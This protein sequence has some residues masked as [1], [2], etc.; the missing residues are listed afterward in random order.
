MSD[1]D[2]PNQIDKLD[3]VVDHSSGPILVISDLHGNLDLL[4]KALSKG[5]EL[6]GREDIDVVLL[7]DYVDNGP[8]VPALLEYLSTEQWRVTHPKLRVHGILGNHDLALLLAL[9]PRDFNARPNWTRKGKNRWTRWTRGFQNGGGQTHLQYDATTQE[10]FTAKFPAHH[11]AWLRG[12]PWYLSMDG[13]LFVHAGI[14]NP[15]LQSVEDQLRYLD[16]KD[17]SDVDHRVDHPHEYG[18]GNYGMPDQLT[19]KNWARRNYPQTGYI[20]VTGHNKFGSG[21]PTKEKADFVASHR[22]GLHACS[23]AIWSNKNLSL[24]CALLPRRAMTSGGCCET[25]GREAEDG[26]VGKDNHQHEAVAATTAEVK[27]SALPRFDTRVA[28][29]LFFQIRYD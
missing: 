21:N 24:H 4:V 16:T 17:L 23:C 2:L 25:R 19:N 14:R 29:P 11:R 26:E 8:A 13:Y 9:D 7:G 6:V 1:P 27:E 3:S 10:Q 12:L 28:K 20:V 22:I 5:V 18:G 15:E